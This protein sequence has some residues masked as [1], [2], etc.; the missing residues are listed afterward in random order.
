MEFQHC[1]RCLVNG[2]VRHN[3]PASAPPIF[4][5]TLHFSTDGVT[6]RRKVLEERVVGDSPAQVVHEQRFAR[7]W[8]VSSRRLLRSDT[9]N[10]TLRLRIPA[11][12]FLSRRSILTG[13]GLRL[14]DTPVEPHIQFCGTKKSNKKERKFCFVRKKR[15]L[16]FTG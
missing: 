14:R 1:H 12:P 13:T 3:G 15:I 16:S 4:A 10:L 8:R 6:F 9:S 11:L 5:A 2:A 7:S